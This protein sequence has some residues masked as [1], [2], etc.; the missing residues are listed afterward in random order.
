MF[1]ICWLL[2]FPNRVIEALVGF[3][4]R[5]EEL[6]LVELPDFCLDVEANV[7]VK[8]VGGYTSV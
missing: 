5:S 6:S 7:D 1:Y 2:K 4:L 3:D 8:A